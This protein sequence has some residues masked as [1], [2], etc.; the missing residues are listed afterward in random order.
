MHVG[1]CT[2]D[3]KPEAVDFLSILTNHCEHWW[4]IGL[5]LKLS[6][7]VLGQIKHDNHSEREYFRVTL[8]KWLQ[9]NCNAT[10]GELELAITN[11]R[12]LALGY[13]SLESLDSKKVVHV[14]CDVVTIMN[15]HCTS[16]Y[17]LYD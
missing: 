15:I 3:D 2:G 17:M 11:A 8:D 5:L 4:D 7:A 9:L 13:K 14:L 16:S 10:W 12:R 6:P 1:Y